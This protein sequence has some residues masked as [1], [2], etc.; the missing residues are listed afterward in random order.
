M[1]IS[2]AGAVGVML[3][4]PLAEDALKH[5]LANSWHCNVVDRARKLRRAALTA[6]YG[7][8]A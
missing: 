8:R 5:V 1:V 6:L 7:P 2:G 3:F 4:K